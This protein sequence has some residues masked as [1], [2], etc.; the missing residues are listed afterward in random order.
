M[1]RRRSDPRFQTVAA[2]EPAAPTRIGSDMGE[3]A[4]SGLLVGLVLALLDRVI[5][6][7]WAELPAIGLLLAVPVLAAWLRLRWVRGRPGGLPQPDQPHEEPHERLVMVNARP[8]EHEEDTRQS[9]FADFVRG[10]AIDTSLR[11]WEPMLGREGY[12]RYRDVLL[13]LG[14]GAWRSKDRRQG[15]EL[16]AEPP[17]ILD[18]LE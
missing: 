18:A 7:E 6:G 4:V 2:W 13:S 9:E 11:R 14:W 3:A 17:V 5:F 8:P 1:K 10:C 15:W 12:D 16:T